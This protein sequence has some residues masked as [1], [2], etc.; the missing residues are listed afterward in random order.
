M[1][2]QAQMF[3]V[4]H[5]CG[6]FI[7][8]SVPAPCTCSTRMPG[9]ANVV[10]AGFDHRLL[11]LSVP[12]EIHRSTTTLLAIL[13]IQNLMFCII[14]SCLMLG[15][16]QSPTVPWVLTIPLLSFF[17]LGSSPDIRLM[18][19]LMFVANFAAFWISSGQ[20][21]RRTEPYR[22]HRGP[23][24]RLRFDGRGRHVC[25]H[26]GAVL[27]QGACERRASSKPKCRT[28]S[29]RRSSFAA[30]RP[31]PTGGCLKSEFLARLS[32]ELRIPLHAV[33]GYSSILV[34]DADERGEAEDVGDLED[35][36]RL[37]PGTA[38]F[39]NDILDLFED[40]NGADGDFQRRVRP[41]RPVAQTS[42]TR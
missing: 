21:A 15:G 13:S 35:H 30:Q 20:R 27:R 4:S 33:I 10:L 25:G 16:I 37:W 9:I 39:V 41:R 8:N 29:P 2:K 11:D 22:A 18:V 12:A 32:S 19:L 34:E 5:I 36:S 40:R 6:P 14:W 31:R 17:Y 26:D 42:S 7:G 1:R 23:G 3:L 28:I 24:A 38:R